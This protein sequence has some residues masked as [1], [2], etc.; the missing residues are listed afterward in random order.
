MSTKTARPT[1]DDSKEK[2]AMDLRTVVSD[3]EELLRATADQAG[4]KA[5]SLRERAQANLTV[6]KARLHETER[7]MIERTRVAAQATDEYVH[8]NPWYAVGVAAGVGLLLG[9]LIGRG[10]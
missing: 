5:A 7:A 6:A 4:E 3:T 10:R 8:E 1:F 2:L 9:M